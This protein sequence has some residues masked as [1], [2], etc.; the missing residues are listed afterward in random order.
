VSPVYA[1]DMISD[2]SIWYRGAIRESSYR[3]TKP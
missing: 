2:A 3:F 1:R